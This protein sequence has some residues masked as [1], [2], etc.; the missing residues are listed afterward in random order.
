MG[1]RT[2]W[3]HTAP[4][5]FEA[6]ID[7]VPLLEVRRI[8]SDG[9]QAIVGSWSQGPLGSS[10]EAKVAALARAAV[11]LALPCLKRFTEGFRD[12]GQP[13]RMLKAQGWINHRHG[14]W[15]LTPAGRKEADRQ[16]WE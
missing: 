9:W 11:L 16:G 10:T 14:C 6:Q 13:R 12:E 3:K 1:M 8:G 15:G 2:R 5:V 4:G 7:G